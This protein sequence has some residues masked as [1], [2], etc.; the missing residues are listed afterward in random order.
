MKKIIFLL[1]I[2]FITGCTTNNQVVKFKMNETEKLAIQILDDDTYKYMIDGE[3]HILKNEQEFV[4]FKYFNEESCKAI[5]SD[6][7]DKMVKELDDGFIYQDDNYNYYYESK[8]GRCLV[9]TTS[10]LE[11]INELLD[12]I[13]IKIVKES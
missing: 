5:V 12:N 6:E 10:T 4:T 9:F 11:K 13:E 7:K 3:F 8:D 1:M 2:I